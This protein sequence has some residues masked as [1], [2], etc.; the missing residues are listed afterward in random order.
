M[1][2]QARGGP[3][4]ERKVSMPYEE[5]RI[6]RSLA[7]RAAVADLG[8]RQRR[9]FEAGDRATWLGTFVVEGV[10]EIDGQEPLQ[11]HGALAKWMGA[12]PRDHVVVEVDAVVEVDGLRGTQESRI[13]VLEP[14]GK[15]VT[16]LLATVDELVHE[17]GRWYFGRRRINPA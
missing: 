17:R 10:L 12:A 14:G 1:A 9:A 4:E 8:A 7:A 11:G 3:K 5:E 13:L 6:L 2:G 16:G 15:S